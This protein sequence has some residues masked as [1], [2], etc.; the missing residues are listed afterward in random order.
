MNLLSRIS[1][2][3][4]LM[5]IVLIGII[6]IKTI[7]K[8]QEVDEE[9]PKMTRQDRI[10][11]YAASIIE[12]VV[13]IFTLN[14]Q[15]NLIYT[16]SILVVTCLLNITSYMDEKIQS[17]HLW[18]CL[19]GILIQAVLYVVSIVKYENY[20]NIICIIAILAILVAMLV[21]SLFGGIGLGDLLLYVM[22]ALSYLTIS[23]LAH[24]LL[25]VNIVVSYI[26]F[27]IRNIMRKKDI[28]KSNPFTLSIAIISFIINSTI[29][30]I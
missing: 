3:Q 9:L 20:I 12:I 27:L 22:I 14:Q 15:Q 21:T 7:L 29:W 6:P 11:L 2:I 23:H 17:F 5:T 24:V 10:L 4:I 28:N 25:A 13:F 16:L 26:V 30:I 1:M 8:I 18:I 19:L